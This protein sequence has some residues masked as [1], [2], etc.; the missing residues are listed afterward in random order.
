MDADVV[1]VRGY[2]RVLVCRGYAGTASPPPARVFH[3]FPLHA[4]LGT[5]GRQEVVMT[6]ERREA[7]RRE[8]EVRRA[9]I[10]PLMEKQ[11]E[12]ERRAFRNERIMRGLALIGACTVIGGVIMLGFFL[13]RVFL[14]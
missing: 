3:D 4:A 1:Q 2:E 9:L 10:L 13:A 14:R 12:A 5:A 7:L 11:A 6:E 8:E